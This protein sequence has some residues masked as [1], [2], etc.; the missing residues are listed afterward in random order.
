MRATSDCLVSSGLFE[1]GKVRC[2]MLDEIFQHDDC[3]NGPVRQV[4]AVYR[5]GRFGLVA[6]WWGLVRIRRLSFL[7]V[8][9]SRFGKQ[10]SRRC[11]VLAGNGV[12][13]LCQALLGP[14]WALMRK[15][16]W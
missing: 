6:I 8:D 1:R 16:R 4:M 3:L 10:S 11:M 9:G 7:N 5:S 2:V 15:F 12:A 14:A 13:G